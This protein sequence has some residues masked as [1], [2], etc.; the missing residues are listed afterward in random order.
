MWLVARR[1]GIALQYWM[2]PGSLARRSTIALLYWKL[3]IVDWVL[4]VICQYRGATLY[5]DN[6]KISW[7][8]DTPVSWYLTGN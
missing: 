6:W 3:T 4:G 1:G 8:R 2:G 5:F 7:W